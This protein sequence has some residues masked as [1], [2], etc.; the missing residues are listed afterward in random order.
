LIQN[1]TLI[2]IGLSSLQKLIF[3]CQWKNQNGSQN[4]ENFSIKLLREINFRNI[5]FWNHNG[6][7]PFYADSFCPLSLTILD[8]EYDGGCLM[9]NGKCLPFVRTWVH[10]QC[11]MQS[12]LRYV[13]DQA[14]LSHIF[15]F[16]DSPTSNR[17][18]KNGQSRENG[19]I[20]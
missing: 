1:C 20:G 10:P 3:F 7:F 15:S 16:L 13:H 17:I 14:C 5:H 9:R 18:I 11:L 6:F 2:I 8:N 4:R 19:N 12:D